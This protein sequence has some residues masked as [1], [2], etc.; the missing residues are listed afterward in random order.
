MD[1]VFSSTLVAPT[2]LSKALPTQNYGQGYGTMPQLDQQQ[3]ISVPMPTQTYGQQL[4]VI[5]QRI[6]P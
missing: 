2:V 5:N 6:L 1:D 3:Q 4:P